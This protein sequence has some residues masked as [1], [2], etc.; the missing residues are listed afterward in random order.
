[1]KT[2]LVYISNDLEE[3]EEFSSLPYV[4]EDT[5]HSC[6]WNFKILEDFKGLPGSQWKEMIILD[7]FNKIKYKITYERF[8]KTS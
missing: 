6:D 8:K 4:M 3:T 2:K 7:F 5:W 1:M